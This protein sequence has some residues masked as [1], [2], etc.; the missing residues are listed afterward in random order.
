[1]ATVYK[2][3]YIEAAH[4]AGESSAL[5]AIAEGVAAK[6]RAFASQHASKRPRG[7]H[8]HDSFSVERANATRAAYVTDRLVVS[9]DPQAKSKEFGHLA[10]NGTW[11]PGQLSLIRAA[12]G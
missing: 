1:M 3:A 2:R 11:V 10:P 6:A 5:T 7:I 8:Y 12:N 4:L 9:S